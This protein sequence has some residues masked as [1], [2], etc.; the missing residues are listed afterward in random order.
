MTE[1]DVLDADNP[2]RWKLRIRVP[3]DWVELAGTQ[4][5]QEAVG[6]IRGALDAV[7]VEL[8][9]HDAGLLLDGL[10]AWRDVWSDRSVLLHGLVYQG[11]EFRGP[12]AIDEEIFLNVVGS[13]RQIDAFDGPLSLLEVIRRVVAAKMGFDLSAAYTEA[14]ETGI[15]PALGMTV[16]YSVDARLPGA[17]AGSAPPAKRDLGLAV[18]V[19]APSDGGPGLVLVGWSSEPQHVRAVGMLLAAMAGP[20]KIVPV[21]AQG[22]EIG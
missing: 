2:T 5:A 18:V 15:G 7:D 8:P 16:T 11:K 21:D 22:E 19:T 12:T 10:L 6:V 13:V 20:A 9:A 1:S 14:F 17:A 4:T 3:D